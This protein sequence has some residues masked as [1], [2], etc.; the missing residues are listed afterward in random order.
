MTGWTPAIMPDH[1]PIFPIFSG[2]HNRKW[3]TCSECHVAPG[4]FKAFECIF[5]HKH[6]QPETDSKHQ[7]I[8]GYVYSSPACYDCHPTGEAEDD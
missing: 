4:N 1:D 6:D 7:G 2:R 5:C 8:T 3:D